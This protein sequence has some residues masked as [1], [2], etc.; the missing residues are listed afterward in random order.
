MRH[1]PCKLACL[2]SA[3]VAIAR[4]DGCFGYIPEA[5]LNYAIRAQDALEA[6]MNASTP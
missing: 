3:T 4:C 5:N 6:I 1:L 2:T